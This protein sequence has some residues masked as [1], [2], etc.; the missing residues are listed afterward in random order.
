ML[1]ARIESRK[2]IDMKKIIVAL[3]TTI[4]TFSLCIP[5]FAAS[6]LEEKQKEVTQ[7]VDSINQQYDT[8]FSLTIT[9]DELSSEEIQNLKDSIVEMAKEQKE[10]K[11]QLR[12]MEMTS[13]KFRSLPQTKASPITKRVATNTNSKIADSKGKF[14]TFTFQISA[15]VT[16]YRGFFTNVT[17]ID[18]KAVT[19]K[20]DW[21]QKS[22]AGHIMG[23]DEGVNISA[24]GDVHYRNN[25]FKLDSY[26]HTISAPIWIFDII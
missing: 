18:S 17:A 25:D 19:P 5:T 6:D 9:S 11:D 13:P 10:L 14:H 16:Y 8:H 22:G 23:D 1:F 2:E 21:K 7:F 24:I 20:L 3:L 26:D 12:E 15:R 4:M